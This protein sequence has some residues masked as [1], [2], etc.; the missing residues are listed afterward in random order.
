MDDTAASDTE[1]EDGREQLLSATDRAC[2]ECGWTNPQGAKF[3]AECGARLDPDSAAASVRKLV[4]LLFCDLVGSTALGERLDPEIFRQV[5]LRY[6]ATCETALHRHR[7]TIEKFIGDAVFCVFGIPTA[8]E[9]DAHRA[10]RAALDLVAGIEELNGGLEAEWGVRLS[11]RI[12]VNTGV[13]F[14]SGFR[15]GQPGVTGDAVNTA[16][17]LEQAARAGEVL[18]GAMT[19]ELIGDLG[20]CVP[21]PPLELKG[22]G[23]RVPAWRLVDID[24]PADEGRT[25]TRDLV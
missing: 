12:G 1:H 15:P 18:I 6:Y 23:G 3:C 8:H 19:R 7:G 9:D 16:A 13:V 17:R 25:T 10:C 21:V 2:P 5:Q 20:I 22:K 4:T 14:A 11:V 24:V